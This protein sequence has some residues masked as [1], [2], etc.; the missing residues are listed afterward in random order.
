MIRLSYPT[1]PFQTHAICFLIQMPGTMI[2]CQSHTAWEIK[3]L[4][5]ARNY[6]ILFT[7]QDC[8]SVARCQHSSQQLA[9]KQKTKTTNPH[10]NTN[11]HTRK[12]PIYKHTCEATFLFLLSSCFSYTGGLLLHLQTNC[13][14]SQKMN[15][16]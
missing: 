4:G 11:K 5:Q 15:I 14:C 8:Y 10:Q 12:P 7:F 1:F 9:N 16:R 2:E 6:E 13:K 3:R